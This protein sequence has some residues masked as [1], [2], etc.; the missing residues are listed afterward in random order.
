MTS[1]VSGRTTTAGSYA[2]SILISSTGCGFLGVGSRPANNPR[3]C[4]LG[5]TSKLPNEAI[6]GFLG[7]GISKLPKGDIYGFLLGISNAPSELIVGSFMP[8]IYSP[9]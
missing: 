5:G 3:V 7:A 4:F 1:Y 2:I 9:P 6:V 8:G